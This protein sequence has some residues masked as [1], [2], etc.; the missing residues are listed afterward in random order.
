ML[1]SSEEIVNIVYLVSPQ[2]LITMPILEAVPDMQKLGDA[3]IAHMVHILEGVSPCEGSSEEE[4]AH[5][6][7]LVR[8][9]RDR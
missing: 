6:H 3:M 7:S 8:S 9:L 1:T 2:Q 5:G 4:Q